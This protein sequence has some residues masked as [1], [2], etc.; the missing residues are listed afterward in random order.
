MRSPLKDKLRPVTSILILFTIYLFSSPLIA[1]D[2]L[3]ANEILERMR[4]VSERVHSFTAD[5][6]LT[7][8]VDFIQMPQ[9]FAAVDF[10][11]P[12]DLEFDSEDFIVIPKRGLDFTYEQIYSAPYTAVLLEEEAI[13]DKSCYVVQVIPKKRAR[14]AIATLHIDAQTFQTRRSEFVTR[15]N[16]TFL[17]EM[18]YDQDEFNL[19]QELTISFEMETFKLPVRYLGKNATIDRAKMRSEEIKE[20]N[21][22]LEF[23]NYQINGSL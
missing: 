14:L 22:L 18:K 16:G 2:S 23:S 4:E 15:K 7:L 11:A 3:S 20:G 17:A 13:D 19:P 21:M 12:D 8:D 5:V 9:K 1:A 6:S 10:Q